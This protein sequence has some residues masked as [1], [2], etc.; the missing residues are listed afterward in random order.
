[1]Q[2]SPPPHTHTWFLC[3]SSSERDHKKPRSWQWPYFF[4]F[5]TP[6]LFH[7]IARIFLPLISVYNYLACK[8]CY[9]SGP[10]LSFRDSP[11]STYGRCIPLNKLTFAFPWLAL[12]FFPPV[13]KP[14][15][16]TWRWVHVKDACRPRDMTAPTPATKQ[17]HSTVPGRQQAGQ[18]S[19]W[20]E[21]EVTS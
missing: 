1:M 8:N 6:S 18:G 9:Q 20:R 17:Q 21:G 11:P 16:L 3:H 14:R 13:E 12:E 2:T 7:K 4:L 5:Q 15:T 10:A 19:S